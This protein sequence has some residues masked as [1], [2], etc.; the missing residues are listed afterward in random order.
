MD[1]LDIVL[2]TCDNSAVHKGGDRFIKSD[3]ITL[4]K[5]CFVSLI[6]SI[7]Q[8]EDADIRLWILDDNSSAELLDFMLRA[9]KEINCKIISLEE[10]GFNYS[11]LKQFEYCRDKG[12]EWVYSVEDDYLHYPQAIK[13]F[14]ADGKHFRTK[15]GQYIAIRPEDDPFSYA[16]NTKFFNLPSRIMLGL[17][18]HWRTTQHTTNT[19]F[20]DVSV[21]KTFW[22]PLAYLAKFYSIL[23]IQENETVNK[24]WGDG[25]KTNGPVPLF[26]PI[27][28]LAFHV[29]YNNRPMYQDYM[30]LWNSINISEV[31]NDTAHFNNGSTRGR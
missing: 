17:D 29:S 18:R 2:R 28:S 10:R 20:T 4:I 26:S 9:S 3:K 14:L 25:V 31:T 19:F 7:K 15:L 23:D 1:L 6:N 5:K 13:M 24:L 27:P 16:E 11:A 21:F 30:A 8:V 22:E 12:R